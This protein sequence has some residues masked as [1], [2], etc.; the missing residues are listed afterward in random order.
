MTLVAGHYPGVIGPALPVALIQLY[1]LAYDFAHVLAK[2]REGAK[3]NPE[4]RPR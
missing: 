2:G 1:G 4:A 3:G